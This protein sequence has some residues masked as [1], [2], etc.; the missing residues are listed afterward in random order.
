MLKQW[1]VVAPDSGVMTTCYEVTS[2]KLP[3]FRAVCK[4][5]AHQ[6]WKLATSNG[7]CTQFQSVLKYKCHFSE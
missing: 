3:A 2:E 6:H 1:F 5:S 7:R 4:V